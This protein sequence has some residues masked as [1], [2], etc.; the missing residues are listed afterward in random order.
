M[1]KTTKNSEFTAFLNISGI[2]I[3]IIISLITVVS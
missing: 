2:I 3:V 1:K